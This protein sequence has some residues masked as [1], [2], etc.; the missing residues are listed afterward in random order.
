MVSRFLPRAV[1]GLLRPSGL[2]VVRTSTLHAHVE[3]ERR[4]AELERRLARADEQRQQDEATVQNIIRYAMKAHWRTVDLIDRVSGDD[5]PKACALCGYADGGFQEVVSECIFSGGRLLRHVCPRCD[6]IFGPQK[7]LALDESMLDLD[8]RM[9]YRTYS[10]GDST[11]S[12]IRTFHLLRPRKEGVYLDFGSGGAWSAAIQR[13][14]QEGWN[15]FGFEPSVPVSSEFVFTKW[16]EIESR[17]FAGILTHNVLEHLFDPAGTTRRLGQLLEPGARL[18]HTTPCF[19]YLYEYTRFHVFFFTGRSPQVLAER[20][21]MKI[22]EWVRD[23][24]FM[25]CIMQRA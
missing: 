13:L 18:V 22:E 5:E 21:G 4:I 16:E 9:L 12:I 11:E 6:V 8:Y 3:L 7:V 24:E 19:E 25:A 1:N 2:Q 20:A 14:R 10:E 15:I 23:G 17:R